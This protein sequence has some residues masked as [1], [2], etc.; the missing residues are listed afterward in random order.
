MDV[1][2]IR[3]DSITTVSRRTTAGR[4]RERSF[5]QAN[6]N[7]C[8]K[9]KKHRFQT[10]SFFGDSLSPWFQ[11]NPRF[12]AILLHLVYPQGIDGSGN[13]PGVEIL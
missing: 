4:G 7:N 12:S 2:I 5:C 13:A 8:T 10:C 11:R 6:D 3:G 1:S 9:N